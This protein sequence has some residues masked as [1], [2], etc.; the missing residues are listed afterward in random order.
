[1]R[2]RDAPGHVRQCL[3]LFYTRSFPGLVIRCVSLNSAVYR[4]RCCTNCC[5]FEPCLKFIMWGRAR[6]PMPSR[7][8]CNGGPMLGSCS[9]LL[10]SLRLLR[11]YSETGGGGVIN[12]FLVITIKTTIIRL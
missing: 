9:W 7:F 4:W 3:L 6:K 1:M 5:T 12:G 11:A 8:L 2:I 10:Y